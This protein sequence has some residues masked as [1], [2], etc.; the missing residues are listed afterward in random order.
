MKNLFMYIKKG[1][2]YIK[3]YGFI[4]GAKKIKRKVSIFKTYSKFN[5]NYKT[6]IYNNEPNENEIK[7]QEKFK[8]NYEPKISILIPMYNTNELFF[9]EL[10]TCLKKQTYKNFE[11]CLADG[12]EVENKNL[13]KYFSDDDRFRYQHLNSNKG[14]SENTNAAL[15]MATGEYIA[16]VDHDDVLPCFALFE[17]IKAINNNPAVE[18]IYSDE[19]ILDSNYE[20]KNPYFKPDFSPY[21]L[22]SCNYICHLS[23]I[24]KT[25]INKIG[26]FRS[27]FDGAQDYDMILRATENA[28]LIV[29]IPKILYHWRAHNN[30]TS[31]NTDSKSYAFIAGKRAIEEQ[32]KRLDIKGSVESLE[33]PGTYKVNYEI[34]NNPFVSIIIPNK[35]SIEDLNKCI[36]SI[37]KSTYSN[38]EIIIVEN[39][40]ES[41]EI[42]EFYNK[43]EKN[44]KNI[45]VVKYIE[46]GFNFSKINNFGRKFAKGEYILLLNNDVEIIS[47]NWIEEMLGICEQKNVGIVGAKLLYPDNSVQ[48]AGVILGIGGVAGHIHKN[49]K[50]S[51]PGYFSRAVIIN[52]F[53]AVTAACML[54]KIDIFDEVEGLDESFEVAFND[55]D[56]C[57]KVRKKG[58]LVVYTPFAK[59]HHFESKSRGLEDTPEKQRRFEGE[60][61]RF[62]NKW[63]EELENGDPYFNKNFRLDSSLFIIDINKKDK[64]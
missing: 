27:Q 39:N 11:V 60:I 4:E 34:I 16:L 41:R 49:I 40:S 13:K 8:F 22:R 36:S 52:N 10:I 44:Y 29:H 28:K 37:L 19:D 54:V 33:T 1:I 50:D 23:V 2:G 38:Y 9:K 48:H 5:D 30:S 53:S 20:R 14:I 6:W 42:F 51:D 43:L 26:K 55:V 17:V 63:H 58:Y 45:H 56:F 61:E 15:D 24:K 59:L 64:G 18:F 7:K 31:Q 57:M 47:E 46:K 21:T 62:K 3:K 35:D 32:L 25:L 12:S